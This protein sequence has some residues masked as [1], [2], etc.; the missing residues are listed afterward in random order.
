MADSEKKVGRT[1]LSPELHFE[2]SF[3]RRQIQTIPVFPWTSNDSL[4]WILFLASEASMAEGILHSLTTITED[5]GQVR[6]NS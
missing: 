2:K 6:K 1:M 4:G 5:S 3:G